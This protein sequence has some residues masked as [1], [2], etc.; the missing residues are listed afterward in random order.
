MRKLNQHWYSLKLC[1]TLALGFTILAV[2]GL[3]QADTVV[4]TYDALNR[5]T[6]IQYDNGVVVEYAYDNAGNRTQRTVLNNNPAPVANAGVDQTVAFGVQVILNGVGSTDP[7]HGPAP[8]TY[9]WSQISGPAV[10]LGGA[11]TATPTFTPTQAGDYVFGLVVNDGQASSPQSTVTVHVG[12]AD[13][14]IGFG[15][16]PT[17]VVGGT[18]IVSATGGASGI[19][20]TFSSTTTGVCTV[21]GST[22]TGL[23]AGSCTVAANQAGN[24]NYNAAPQ[25]T[26]TINVGKGTQ[27]IGFSLA[28]VV[29]VGG[30][31]TVS[32][33]GG[34]SGNPVTFSS[35]TPAVCTTGG[36]NGSTVTGV[37]VGNCVVAANQA[38]DAN[39]NAAAQAT[40]TINVGK[41]TQ[42]IGFSLA[43]VVV[44]GG[45]GTVSAM[46]GA[47]GNPVT[48]SSTTPAVCTTGGSN[49]STVTGVT[50]GNCVVA[51][52][53]AGDANYNAATQATQTLAVGKGS[54][55]ISFGAAPSVN[56]GGTGTVS[57]TGGASGNPVTFGSTTT[58]VCTV[59]SST[60]TGL[61]AGSCTIAANQAGNANYN[62]A[63]QAI[64][65]F[66]VSQIQTITPSDC[67]FNWAEKNYPTLFAP[68]GSSTAVWSTF[69]YRHYSATN[70]YLGVSSSD[71]HVY[72]MGPDGILQDEGPLADWLPKAGCQAPPPP[73]DECL[74]AWA[75][76]NYPALFSPAGSPTAIWTVYTYRYY[77][78][79]N[80]SL[81]ISS[82]D[83][84]VYYQGIDGILRDEGPL[85]K[86]LPLAGCQ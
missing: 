47:S 35:T 34:A 64:Q 14:A 38:G 71:N 22:A 73:Q 28:P 70:T 9:A 18:G 78:T 33:M 79:T 10:T 2:A 49:G 55:T 46:G 8:L 6:R 32:A 59:S 68:S 66:T 17:L 85:S 11:T 54:Q 62:A 41:G 19:P 86:W 69:S 13:Q 5:I 45:T 4:N 75:E 50:V 65:T 29:V 37:T 12:K 25:A 60:V 16:A 27:T 15:P 26:Q 23:S 67:L 82:A 42:T 76:K 53:Q 44:V 77:S 57:A 52:N 40:Q 30:T 56:V 72:Y 20:V 61:S 58:A 1:R 39:Y 51:A 81:G 84:H 74:F 36:S 7:D 63:P 3:A 21:S 48:F 80:A 31:G 24:A 83:N 43:P